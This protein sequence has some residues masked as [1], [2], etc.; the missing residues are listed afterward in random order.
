MIP[1]A[2]ALRRF[3]VV[4]V[5]V[6]LS[7]IMFAAGTAFGADDY[8]TWTDSTNI[9]LNTS[10][11][12]AN[13]AGTVTNFPVL[14]RL[15]ATN[16][17]GFAK[18]KKTGED[19]RFATSG[20]THLQYQIERWDSTNHVAEI[21]VN[22]DQILGGNN[23]QYIKMFW[24]NAG[25]ADNSNGPAVFDTANGYL[26]AW[27]L[28]NVNSVTDATVNNNTGT[29]TAATNV[30]G[31]IGSAASF[32]GSS[33]TISIPSA[34]F[35]HLTT[36]GT[37]SFWQYGDDTQPLDGGT[38]GT[39]YWD[40]GNS[41][42]TCDRISQAATLSSQIKG[43]WNLWTFVR[44]AAAGSMIIYYNGASWRIGGL[45]AY[46][47][48]GISNFAIGSSI[49]AN[50]Y[51]GYLDEFVASRT[52]RSA[53][54][55]R[56]CFQNQQANQ[57]LVCIAP[58]I[59]THPS[60]VSDTAGNTA[61]F[62]IVPFGS[63]TTYQW[64]RSPNGTTW[65][66]VTGGTSTQLNVAN[67]SS[68]DNG[69]Q[70][71]CKVTNSCGLA[72]TSNAA[73]LTVCTPPSFSTQPVSWSG[74]VNTTASYS[75]A[76]ASGVTSP[77]YQ[78]Q[79]STAGVPW[80][81]VASG[82]TTASYSFTAALSN[83]GMMFR[84][85]VTNACGTGYSSIVNCSVCTP[86]S[87]TSHPSPQSV[88]ALQNATF[89]A[90]ASGDATLA[91]LWQSSPN[92]S[93]WT[94][95]TA[96]T[97]ATYTF[98]APYADNGKQ[99][100]CKVTNSCSNSYG[101][102]AYS[103]PALLT[104][105]QP[106]S[107]GVNPSDQYVVLSLQDSFTV[108]ASG[109]GTLSYKWQDSA[110]G[111]PWADIPSATAPSYIFTAQ[112]ANNGKRFRCVVWNGCGDSAYST[113]ALLT[114]CDPPQIASN[115]SN[116]SDTADRSSSFSVT[117]SGTSPL[118]Y[119]WQDSA[120]GTTAWADVLTGGTGATYTFTP[121]TNQDGWKFRCVVTGQ[122]GS[123]AVSAAALLSVCTPPA[124]ATQ[125]AVPPLQ[126]VGDSVSMNI[127]LAA[128]VTG[129]SYQW[130]DSL[131]GTSAWTNATEP[132][133][134]SD[135]YKFAVAAGDMDGKFRCQVTN[136]CG[137][138][139]SNAV[140]LT[141]CTPPSI[142]ANP[143]NVSDTVGNT[144]TFTVA[145][146]GSGTLLYQW[147][148]SA[149]G[150]AWANVAT[151]GTA[152]TYAFA[153]TSI[154]DGMWFRCV[155][156]GQCE[157]HATSSGA[158]LTVC[159]PPALS[160]QP[161]SQTK[162]AGE[163]A[164]FGVTLPA[165][166]TSPSYQWQRSN[167]TAKTWTNATGASATTASY[168]F[169]AA[170]GDDASQYNCIISNSC[171][172]LT[173]SNATLSICT[174]PQITAQPA[175]LNA[176]AGS[177]A[178]LTIAATG[179]PAPSFQWQYSVDTGKTWNPVTSGGTSV[180]YGFTPAS[181]QD[182]W[183]FRC[184]VSNGCGTPVT[185]NAATM[186]VCTVPDI[187]TQPA[188]QNKN[189]G[190]TAVF[191]SSATGS[192]LTYQWQRSPDGTT[193]TNVTT[194]T[195]ATSGSYTM[196]VAATDNGAK[197]RCFVQNTC[198][199]DSSTAATLVVCL[200]PQITSQP[201][202]TGVIAGQ[203]ALFNV[204]CVGT[205]VAYQ[206]QRSD[207]SLTWTPIANQN[208]AS[209]SR[210]TVSADNGAKFKCVITTKCGDTISSVAALAVCTPAGL[211]SQFVTNKS[212]L[213]GESVSF[214]VVGHGTGLTYS[215]Q[216]KAN[217]AS[218]FTDITNPAAA[219]SFATQISD[220]ASLYR[221]I[222]SGQCG[223][224]ETTQT[225]Q[226]LV[227]MP[228]HAAF[229]A[230]A[231][232]GQAPLTVQFFDSSTGSFT[233]R[234]WDFGDGSK[235]DSTTQNP[236]HTY[237]LANTYTAKL[238]VSGPLPRV[239]SSA[240]TQILTWNPGGNPMQI[241]GSY[242]P[243][244]KV[245]Y[246]ISNYKSIVPP[247]P[248]VNVDSVVLWYKSGGQPQS[249][250]ASTFLKGYT[251]A[252][253]TARGSQYTDTVAMPALAAGDS[254]YGFMTSILWSDG[255]RSA[256]GFGNGTVVLMKDTTPVANQIIISGTY[257]PNDTARILLDNVSS[258][259]TSR[260]DTV[261]IWY[262]LAGSTVNFKDAAATRWVAAR[263]VVAAG[264]KYAFTIVNSQFNNEKRTMYAAVVLLGTNDRQSPVRQTSFSVGKD[265]PANPIKLFAKALSSNRIRLN[266]NNV[267]STGVERL[268]I[269][270]RTGQPVP[271]SYDFSA[272]K[273]DSLVPSVGDTVIIGDKFTERTKYYFGA[274]VYKNGLWSYVT[275]SSSATDSTWE[276]G[277]KLDSNSC[278]VTRLYLDTLTNQIRVCWSVD[279]AQAE[280]LQVGVLYSTASV[281]VSDNGNQQAVD[282]KAA[283][284]S[285]FIKL[286]ENLQF[287]T[288]YYVSLWLRRAGGKWT[289]PT[290]RAVDSLKVG[291]FTWQSVTYFSKEKDTV[292]SFNNKIRLLNTPGDLSRTPN[293]V[294]YTSPAGATAG[295]FVPVSIGIDFRVKD[296]GLPL[297]IGLKVDSVPQGHT[298]ADVRIYR[299]NAAGL[300]FIDEN[301]LTY[302]SSGMYVS[303]LTNQIGQ[304]FFAMVDTR[305]PTEKV[306]SITTT[307]IKPDI[308]YSDTIQ[309]SDNIANLRWRFLSAKGGA[310][311]AD[312]DTN[313]SGV[314]SDTTGMAIV[315][316]PGSSVSQDN[317]VRAVLIVS[318]GVHVDTVELWRS[319]AR[320]SSGVL[321]TEELKWAPLSTAY[322]LDT[323]EMR[324]A[325]AMYASDDGSW[326]YDPK[327]FRVFKWTGQENNGGWMEY[328]DSVRTV[329]EFVRGNLVWIKT[330]QNAEIE[331]G[332]G[333][334]P[335][336]SSKDPFI[337]ALAPKS[338]TDF[339]IPYKF[340]IAIGDILSA[341]KSGHG[342]T[343]SLGFY[344]WKKD[345][346][347]SFHSEAVFIK[348][349]SDTSLNNEAKALVSEDLTG[350]TVFND[351]ADTVLLRIPPVPQ[352][353]STAGLSKRSMKRA[354]S[355]ASGA[356]AIRIEARLS[357]STVLSPVYCGFSKGAFG[358]TSYYP[359]APS[360]AMARVAVFDATLKKTAGLAVAHST[361]SGG[362]AF[363]LSF[364]NETDRAEKVSYRLENL[365]SL[366]RGL[367]AA[368]FNAATQQFESASFGASREQGIVTLDAHSTGFRWLLVG[369]AD[370]LAK[371]GRIARPA[372][373]ALMGTYPNPFRTMVRIRFSLP[374]EGVD[375]VKFTI[376][377]VRGR[378]VWHS[379]V[380]CGT[381]Y[382]P[383]D[384][385]W[386]TMSSDNRPVAAGI[387]IVKM[388][389]INGNHKVVGAF[390][391]KMMF[392]P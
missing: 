136:A 341:T 358:G 177:A 138:I 218:A 179:T 196:T 317:G 113:A 310:A 52:V 201:R 343:D 237:V 295:A 59:V 312:G 283:Q 289:D 381:K 330:K 35:S 267:A 36:A 82:G 233:T 19:I 263:S 251:L 39:I 90:A 166:V 3:P 122:C 129:P 377:D 71:R 86:P 116:R 139:I 13:V 21:W 165:G 208:N 380:A 225:A 236:T 199:K 123:P 320:S 194:G 173:S 338:W 266:W 336:L 106:P 247:S 391:R 155:V 109:S 378:S 185:S 279:A 313:Q 161:A 80:A 308:G 144:A 205:N 74:A 268:I 64:E 198:G 184:I 107:I 217:G 299:R 172:S 47:M 222:V 323:T 160:Q 246:V 7:S 132:T 133:A 146:S 372:M 154:M 151:G 117:A 332:S 277:S 228:L 22:V 32:N 27:H 163:T 203:T 364:S 73:T 315:T 276:A 227:Y 339:S 100:R 125:P 23:S 189:I 49:G 178:S 191:T 209:Y 171:G 216:K 290:S 46:G 269:W 101:S 272:I 5:I 145:A 69:S 66:N 375:K 334:T 51:K 45:Y 127:V 102:P 126:Q 170:S 37:F 356:W 16:F 162:M 150:R 143:Q 137:T 296:P 352:A 202:D 204:T 110:T 26:G 15:N 244:Q 175:D 108:S 149:S 219:Y 182:G 31:I 259:D 12:G 103:N 373:L 275:D 58:S 153:T 65:T 318:D 187:V 256:F 300:W 353:M 192:S 28:Q 142:T 135:T 307:T 238:T 350:Y 200:P 365:S 337:L 147:Q 41:G 186:H 229:R 302:D 119:Q 92:G 181:N 30:T 121:A 50:Y 78:W 169:T 232:N 33:A 254:V 258:I 354:K 156:T 54:W 159:T 367:S 363:L 25:A 115:P 34:A 188:P 195:G 386:N 91:Y 362:C 333:K 234:I 75:V 245:V 253:L 235:P 14:V 262:S 29:N 94:D 97:S 241:S 197:L 292:F 322:I 9:T 316:I 301:P 190:E 345:G 287:N 95:I 321:R 374:Y 193:W 286:R 53:D 382:G 344:T 77:T 81:D 281:P 223:A 379:D 278:D 376:F 366:P 89:T 4:P 176:V 17:N 131:V 328:A 180:T 389:A 306:I 239:A 72:D 392:V 114:I 96:A 257:A 140:T 371:A 304:P 99:Y 55:I 384:L 314:L 183:Q 319:V 43:Q 214:R 158:S 361:K 271:K 79:D 224:P 370:Y 210:T 8:S 265:R 248:L 331:F 213:T 355:A 273:L 385:V 348:A 148:D 387:Y 18:A 293:T 388:V 44:G 104:V 326:T 226:V 309:L 60:N 242:L 93:T 141:V 252:A 20:G 10:A 84:C 282:V 98:A 174:Q 297:Y 24:G 261:G 369:T 305:S 70:F 294:V 349:V 118:S 284:D 134:T 220:S 40:A 250:A 2:A 324:N 83:N 207:N 105:C 357:D 38:Y 285:V 42:A 342:E 230:S 274:Q 111:V 206:W 264:T 1:S 211:D 128:G 390:Q 215:W 48:T 351:Y 221:C 157:P 346:N 311:Y 164:T 383:T 260:V 76:L 327:Y 249:A 329:F 85:R 62:T 61:V 63:G 360:F 368:V 130:Q 359:S 270:Y 124:I 56:L 6:L 112:S 231:T 255:K 57:T 291:Q 11:S 347:G 288:T 280:S 243:Q 120:T 340:N 167:D 152:A 325:L 87:I 335:S 68:A 212:V 303:V 168:S 240:Q 67:V 88:V 298:L